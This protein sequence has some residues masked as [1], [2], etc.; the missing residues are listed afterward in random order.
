MNILAE[1]DLTLASEFLSLDCSPGERASNVID[2][3]NV[4]KEVQLQ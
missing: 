4:I 2:Y 1:E 3:N